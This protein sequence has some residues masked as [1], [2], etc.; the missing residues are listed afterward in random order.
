MFLLTSVAY[1][2]ALGLSL[3]LIIQSLV[4]ND[5][6]LSKIELTALAEQSLHKS[7]M[8]TLVIHALSLFCV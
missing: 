2:A 4:K 6:H 5:V 7:D 8:A 3:V 1:V